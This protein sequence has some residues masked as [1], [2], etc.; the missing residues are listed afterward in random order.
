VCWS[1]ELGNILGLCHLILLA[2]NFQKPKEAV[3]FLGQGSPEHNSW[4]IFISFPPL[5]TEHRTC[6]PVAVMQGFLAQPWNS[7]VGTFLLLLLLLAGQRAS[8]S[9]EE[10]GPEQGRSLHHSEQSL[11]PNR[12]ISHPAV[13]ER[14]HGALAHCNSGSYYNEF[15]CQSPAFVRCADMSCVFRCSESLMS[16]VRN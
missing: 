9:L 16:L 2:V 8:E 3:D 13:T 14:K 7:P 10:E 6:K 5:L 4:V 1:L 12:S 15:I 11:L